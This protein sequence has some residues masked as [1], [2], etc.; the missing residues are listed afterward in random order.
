MNFIK[1]LQLML[2]LEVGD[3]DKPCAILFGPFVGELYW[4]A[5]RFATML[6]FWKNYYKNK[7]N[8]KFIVLT[9]EDRFDLYGKYADVLVPLR[10]PGDYE[11]KMPECFRLQ[12]LKLGPYEKIAADFKNKYQKKY[13]ILKHIYP[14]IKKPHFQEK[15]QFSRKQMIFNFAPRKKNYELVDKYLPN[16]GKP[17]VVLG[18]R[19]RNGF[20]RNWKHWKKFYDLL[21]K[22]TNLLNDFNFVICGKEGE[23]VPDEKNRFFDMNT[24]PLE[25]GASLV[26]ILMVILE[27]AFFTFGSQSAIPN[28]SLLYKVDVLEFGCQRSLH[29]KTYNVKNTPIKFIDNRRY[30]IDPNHILKKLTG[31]LYAK[32][33]K[34]YASIKK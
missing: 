17:I 13:T 33:E 30:D 21:S 10:I 28:M 18:S 9:R 8:V 29:T 24:I 4:E 16:G 11:G 31:L 27:R 2:N 22:R 32:K 34:K 15:N 12:G 14:N 1:E 19:Y 26:G 5:G 25:K 7:K 23:Y 20:K 6:P 3:M